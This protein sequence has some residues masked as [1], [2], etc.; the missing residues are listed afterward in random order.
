VPDLNAV[1]MVR[2]GGSVM[3]GGQAWIL[4]AITIKTRSCLAGPSLNSID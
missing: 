2:V 1:M 4:L 3:P